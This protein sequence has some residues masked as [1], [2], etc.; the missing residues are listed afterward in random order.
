[1]PAET[2]RHNTGAP[3]RPL[4]PNLRK[5]DGGAGIG[6]SNRPDLS[7]ADDI[8]NVSLRLVRSACPAPQKHIPEI[9]DGWTALRSS[10]RRLCVAASINTQVWTEAESYLGPDAAIAVLAGTIPR[11]DDC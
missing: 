6:R 1:M 10:G 8:A 7:P 5:K 2:D 9:F 11:T 3:A 4:L